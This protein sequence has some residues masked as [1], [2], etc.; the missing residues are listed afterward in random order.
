MEIRQGPDF[1]NPLG[2]NYLIQIVGLV[3]QV[4]YTLEVLI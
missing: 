4:V 2:P 3:R 1:R